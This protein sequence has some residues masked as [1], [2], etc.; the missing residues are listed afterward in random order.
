LSVR[1]NALIVWSSGKYSAFARREA[2]RGG[3]LN[4]VGALTTVTGIFERVSVP[5]LREGLL[6]AQPDVHGFPAT[7]AHSRSVP[8]RV[9]LPRSA[10]HA[11]C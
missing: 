7:V 2:G 5:G 4:I 6:H 11:E 3:A 1:P 10:A 8:E 9:R